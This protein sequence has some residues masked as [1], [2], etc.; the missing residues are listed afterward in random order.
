M[1][2]EESRI[3]LIDDFEVARTMLRIALRESG[4]HRFEEATNGRLGLQKM[5]EALA[6]GQPY[7]LVFCDWNMPEMDGLQLLTTVRQTPGLSTVSFVMV[8]SEG[9]KSSIQT[10]MQA[11]ATDYVLKPFTPQTF[12]PK[13]EKLRH[14]LQSA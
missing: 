13:L 4:F 10:A 2:F 11:G 9:E 6:K 12:S 14:L 3:L 5:Q 7:E 8:T 1:T